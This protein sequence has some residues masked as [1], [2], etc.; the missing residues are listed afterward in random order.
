VLLLVVVVGRLDDGGVDGVRL[1][2]A[3]LARA[4]AGG[5][6]AAGAQGRLLVGG[7]ARGPRGPRLAPAGGDAAGGRG[8]APGGRLVG[9]QEPVVVIDRGHG[10]ASEGAH[11]A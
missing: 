9:L 7:G 5:A 3:A 11:G 10:R 1:G 8:Q 6:Q 2:R 4:P